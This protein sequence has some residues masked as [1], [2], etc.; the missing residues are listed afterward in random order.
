MAELRAAAGLPSHLG[1]CGV[2]AAALG[3]MAD[4]AAEQWTAQFNPRAVASDDLRRLY[5]AAL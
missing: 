2:D 1:E 3:A 5:E 4:E